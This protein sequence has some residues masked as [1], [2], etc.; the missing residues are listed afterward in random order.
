LLDWVE[1]RGPVVGR[2]FLNHGD[3]DAREEM[4]RLLATRGFDPEHIVL[5]R[6]DESFELVAGD[7]KSKGRLPQRVPQAELL[8][9]WNND[10][11]AFLVTLTRRLQDAKND[12]ERRE[13]I[14]GLSKAL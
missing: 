1:E 12:E 10:Y 8:T 3:D 2:L 5:P 7:A 6:M 9:D 11:A 4:A 13:I 14:A